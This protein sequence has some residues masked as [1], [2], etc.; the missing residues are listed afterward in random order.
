[1]KDSI[2]NN[3]PKGIQATHMGHLNAA[4]NMNTFL[5]ACKVALSKGQIVIYDEATGSATI[6]DHSGMTSV[7][8]HR[9]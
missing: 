5:L 1:M 2:G 3:L 8:S 7:V 6:T 4:L 9:Y